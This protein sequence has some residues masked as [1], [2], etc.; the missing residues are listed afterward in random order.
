MEPTPEPSIIPIL[1]PSLVR[2]G[3]SDGEIR[4]LRQNGTWASVRRGGYLPT[5]VITPLDRTDRHAILVRATLPGLRVPAVVS[6][7]SAAVLLGIPLWSTHLGIVQLTRQPPA[8]NGQSAKLMIHV[9]AIDADETCVVDGITVT[10]PTRTITDLARVLPFEQAVVAADAALRLRLTTKERLTL[11]AARIAGTPG[12]RAVQRVVQFADGLSESVGES[13]SRVM[14]HLADL[15]A[16]ILQLKVHNGQGRLLGRCDYGWKDGRLLG[17]F[18]GLVKYGRLLL[19]GETSGDKI[20]KEK[21]R[22]DLLRDTGARVVRW[23]W[24]ELDRPD[25]LR[26]RIQHALNAVGG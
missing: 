3:F 8:R 23:V 21:R 10:D 25:R 11:A 24:A 26:V 22:E 14:M 6:H 20:V 13:R 9:S 5:D 19:P 2:R 15:P 7:C 12:S 18:D 1:R 16:P 17:E 4:R